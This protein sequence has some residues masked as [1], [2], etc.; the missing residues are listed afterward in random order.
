MSG[1][2]LLYAA[3]H[4]NHAGNWTSISDEARAK[5]EAAAQGLFAP[6]DAKIA[7]LEAENKRLREALEPSAATKAAYIGEVKESIVLTDENGDETVHEF[8]ISWTAMKEVIG[9]IRA[10]AALAGNPQEEVGS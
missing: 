2:Q 10:R 6:R 4:P 5:Y 1:G 8:A 9:L 3:V 7:T